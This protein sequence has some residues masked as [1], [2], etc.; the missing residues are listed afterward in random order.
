MSD[1]QLRHSYGD[2]GGIDGSPERAYPIMRVHLFAGQPSKSEY[3]D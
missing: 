1:C 3:R 2:M